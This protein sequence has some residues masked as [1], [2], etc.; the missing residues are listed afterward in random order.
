METK[1]SGRVIDDETLTWAI[2]D[3]ERV[4]SEE[5]AGRSDAWPT[6]AA[7]AYWQNAQV[8]RRILA[9]PQHP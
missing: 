1:T 2:R 9:A 5:Q 3:C 6:A 7:V 4:I 8:L